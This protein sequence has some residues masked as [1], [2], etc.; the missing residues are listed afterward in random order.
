MIKQNCSL[1]GLADLHTTHFKSLGYTKNKTTKSKF[2]DAKSPPQLN[3]NIF[4]FIF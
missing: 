3:F 1:L 2:Q 4:H